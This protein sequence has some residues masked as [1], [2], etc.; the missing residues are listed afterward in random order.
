MLSLLGEG[1]MGVVYRAEHVVLGRHAAIKVLL[2]HVARE[3][4]LV[5]RFLNEARIAAT[6][7]HRN[8]VDV[9]DCGMFPAPDAPN[10]QWYIALEFLEGKSLGAFIAEHNGKSIDIQ[11]IIHVIGEAAN[12]LHAAHERHQLVHRDVKPDNI[13]LTRAED[14]P[15][16]VKVLDFGIAKLRAQASGVETRSQTVMGTPAYA[17]PEQLRDSKEV[18]SR[19]D[20]WAL[21]VI[22][23]EMITG[24]R[25]WGAT[26]SVW[27]IIARQSALQRA[28]D[29][30]E[31]RPD[32]PEKVAAVISRAME[33][34]LRRRWKSAK[35]FACALADAASM[36][37]S[38]NGMA[39][40]ERYAPELTRASMHSVTFGRPM[41]ETVR[42]A[43]PQIITANE[44]PQL[45]A[46]HAAHSDYS[47]ST[48]DQLEPTRPISTIAASAG[49]SVPPL[50]PQ[51]G[52]GRWLAAAALGVVVVAAVAVF[53]L[54]RRPDAE[55]PAVSAPTAVMDAG[56]P[57]ADASPTTSTV[58]IITEPAGGDVFVGGV[59]KGRAPLEL[60]L[61]IGSKVELRVESPGFSPATRLVT[62]EPTAATL[63]VELAPIVDAG[64]PATPVDA[65][66]AK[67]EPVKRGDSPHERKRNGSGT[68]PSG[69]GADQGFNP[70]DVL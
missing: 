40:L 26:T 36:P 27:E 70:N 63:R 24:V 47:P 53:V 54:S 20:V 49:Q 64:L 8:I 45:G 33:P 44:R 42:A 65:P 43:P 61:P 69:S 17:A 55:K 51:R 21:G 11:T 23:H 14:D 62:V 19:A 10:G 46:H 12:G 28:P 39:I 41:P 15:I 5:Q 4:V 31:F 18:D 60:E 32:T 48:S 57:R 30:R 2:P 67:K 13:F 25:P 50:S 1:G 66:P 9:L 37:Y 7:N 22:A 38:I 6:L 58:Q 68:P 29:P 56:V 16:R 34:E 52:R 59:R 35:A 3:A